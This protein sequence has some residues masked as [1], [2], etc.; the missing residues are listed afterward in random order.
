[1]S[2]LKYYKPRTPS[3]RHRVTVSRS[4]LHKGKPHKPLTKGLIKTG[5]RN[6]QGR[7]TSYHRGGGAK[8]L[9]RFIDFKRNED[10][11]YIGKVIRLEYDP[12]RTAFIALVYSKETNS[13][14]YIIAPEKLEI[15][16]TIQSSHKSDISI[17]TGNTLKLKH[18]P[19][20]IPIHNIEL[21]PGKGGQL[22]RSAGTYAEI[23]KKGDDGYASVSLPSGEVRYI[24]L[25]CKATVGIVSNYNHKNIKLGKAGA[26]R[27]L[28][29]RPVVRGV[30]MNPVD[31]P[32]GGGEG[33]TSGGRPSV[34]PWG[35][36][37]K[38]YK[39]RKKPNPWIV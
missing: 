15:G 2:K 19:V 16:S 22:V 28:G 5:G 31:H 32:H 18:L 12:N 3:L 1:M 7:I 36:P 21:Y 30:A 11:N 10:S 35:R 20:N 27:W 4:T 37:T 23:V 39:T 13:Y 6:N 14:K 26:S 9:Y 34:T 25:D 38:G 33:K 24:R 17:V 29:K 8:R